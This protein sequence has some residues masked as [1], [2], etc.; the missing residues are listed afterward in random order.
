MVRVREINPDIKTKLSIA[1]DSKPILDF[2][3]TMLLHAFGVILRPSRN[4]RR[5]I[6][7]ADIAPA[8]PIFKPEND[9]EFVEDILYIESKIK[10]TTKEYSG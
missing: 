1:E 9:R 7:L 5:P 8:I 6:Y 3:Q 2:D 10:W 4:E